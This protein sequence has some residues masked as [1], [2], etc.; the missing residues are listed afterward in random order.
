MELISLT[1][2]SDLQ[3]GILDLLFVCLF[4][5][6]QEDNKRKSSLYNSE[7]K[8]VLKN[9]YKQIPNSAL[10]NGKPDVVNPNR[11]INKHNTGNVLCSVRRNSCCEDVFGVCTPWLISFIAISSGVKT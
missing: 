3:Q 4:Q 11:I 1:E 9:D 10:A 5:L 6:P 7:Q 2:T 8:P